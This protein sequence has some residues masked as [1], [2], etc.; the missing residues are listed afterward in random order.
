MF[1]A[2]H[3]QS[4]YPPDTSP[5][6]QPIKYAGQ[7]HDCFVYLSL[8]GQPYRCQNNDEQDVCRRNVFNKGQYVLPIHLFIK[9]GGF[10]PPLI[11]FYINYIPYFADL[12]SS[13]SIRN[14]WLYFAIRSERDIEPV[15]ICPAFV[16]TA[17]SA[18]VVSSVSPLRCEIITP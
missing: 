4:Q 18:I 13:S 12:S 2:G 10:A 9:I 14:N 15:L 3:K 17:R 5:T 16:A 8:A 6:K 7:A 1:F 11:L